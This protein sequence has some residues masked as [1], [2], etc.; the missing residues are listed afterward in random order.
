V[1]IPVKIVGCCKKVR[2][3]NAARMFRNPAPILSISTVANLLAGPSPKAI[4]EVGAGC[5]RNALFLLRAGHRLTVLEVPRMAERF[6]EQY[7]EFERAGG[8]VLKSF[9]GS[10]RFEIALLTFVVETICEPKERIGLLQAVRSHLKPGGTLVL[11]ARGPKD[12]LTA[13]NK[14]IRCRDGY[15]TPNFSFAR[16]YT[17]AQMERVLKAA[18]FSELQ[19]LH[20]D[21]SKEPEYLHVIARTND[22]RA[23]KRG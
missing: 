21:S 7:D 14:G 1:T 19:F 12:L 22:E 2:P 10:P 9:A 11:S 13:Q 18:G 16:S 8:K 5:L 23:R 6:P 17:R 15:L 3:E 20:K 4:L